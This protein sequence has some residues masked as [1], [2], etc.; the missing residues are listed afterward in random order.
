MIKL[1]CPACGDSGDW[2]VN[3]RGETWFDPAGREVAVVTGACGR[4]SSRVLLDPSPEAVE[5][6]RFRE[7]SRR[8]RAA[9]ARA[10]LA[11]I[12]RDEGVMADG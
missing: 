3:G 5:R 8:D 1:A 10:A 4:C 2:T 7:Q 11:G 12:Q 6:I 9:T